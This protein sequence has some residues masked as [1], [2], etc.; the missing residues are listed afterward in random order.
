LL[1][2]AQPSTTGCCWSS[3][4]RDPSA[5]PRPDRARHA[6]FGRPPRARGH[7]YGCCGSWRI[8]RRTRRV[9]WQRR[10]GSWTRSRHAL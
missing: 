1:V 6:P 8:A 7:W 4:D 3:S 2:A 5:R 10:R 9:C